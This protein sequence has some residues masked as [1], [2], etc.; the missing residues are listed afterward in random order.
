M[1]NF[2]FSNKNNSNLVYSRISLTLAAM[3]VNKLTDH[4]TTINTDAMSSQNNINSNTN[5]NVN[6]SSRPLSLNQL[7][8]RIVRQDINLDKKNKNSNY[9]SNSKSIILAPQRVVAPWLRRS[10]HSEFQLYL[11]DNLNFSH[12]QASTFKLNPF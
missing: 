11:L 1:Q 10:I 9:Y 6:T 7:T 3:I 5:L 8:K 2:Q 4:I 12:K